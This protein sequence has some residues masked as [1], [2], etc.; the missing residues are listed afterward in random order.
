MLKEHVDCNMQTQTRVCLYFQTA[1]AC[2]CNR[3]PIARSDLEKKG[4]HVWYRT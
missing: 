4:S 3:S 2:F 1:V